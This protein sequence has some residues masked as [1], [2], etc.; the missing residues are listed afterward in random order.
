MSNRLTIWKGFEI[1]LIVHMRRWSVNYIITQIRGKLAPRAF[2]AATTLQRKSSS[3]VSAQIKRHRP[4]AAARRS[5]MPTFVEPNA[6]YT[7]REAVFRSCVVIR[8]ETRR[9]EN[10][11]FCARR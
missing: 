11:V 6:A 3:P 10:V 9:L 8:V 2:D 1:V 7:C 4:D 5:P